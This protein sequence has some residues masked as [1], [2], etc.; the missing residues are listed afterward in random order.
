MSL[1]VQDLSFAYANQQ[2]LHEVNFSAEDGELL[3]VLGPNGVGKTTLFRCILGLRQAY[4]GS[5]F[6]NGADARTLSARQLAHRIAY[7]PQTHGMAFNYSVLDV[8]LMGTT[9]SVGAMSVPKEIEL[10][11]ANDALERMDIAALKHKNFSKLSGGEQQL[12]L[13]AR[14]LAQNAKTLLMDEPTASLDYGNQTLVLRQVRALADN[15]YTVLLSTHNP[16]HALW[17]ADCV[18]GFVDGKI[19]KFG[20][21]HDVVDEALILKLYG[22]DV[23]IIHTE[24]GPLISPEI[25]VRGKEEESKHV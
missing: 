15:G 20:P 9:H 13:I 14:A 3:A 22:V 10:N 24:H 7:I 18:I 5:I 12:V 25:T 16:Q 4:T 1:E 2:V 11:A 8:V 23:K 6:I 21:P 17:Y 19:L